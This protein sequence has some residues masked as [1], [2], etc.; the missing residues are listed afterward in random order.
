MGLSSFKVWSLNHICRKCNNAA[1]IL[2]MTAS[3]STETQ[4]WVE[5]TPL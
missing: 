4:V 3:S 5:D 1:H 2:A